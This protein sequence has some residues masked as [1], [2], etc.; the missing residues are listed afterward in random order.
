MGV[1]AD[2]P[3]ACRDPHA[4]FVLPP[5][6]ERES[7][8][9]LASGSNARTVVRAGSVAGVWM[10]RDRKREG[11]VCGCHG[12]GSGKCTAGLKGS[13]YKSFIAQAVLL[14]YPP[15]CLSH[16]QRFCASVFQLILHTL[17]LPLTDEK[18]L[19]EIRELFQ[20]YD[21]DG[22]GE[23]CGFGWVIG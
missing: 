12:S 21:A 15:E 19:Q 7:G 22:S 14:S 20:M 18:K 3:L 9:H 1:T 10:I 4:N 11:Q 16:F 8:G 2:Q 6:V 13:T 17:P 5:P 23:R